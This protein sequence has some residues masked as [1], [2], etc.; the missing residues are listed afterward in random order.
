METGV[1]AL[2]HHHAAGVPAWLMDVSWAAVQQQEDAT[3]WLSDAKQSFALVQRDSI[4][5]VVHA[6]LPLW[7]DTVLDL[8]T[9]SPL[10]FSH[11]KIRRE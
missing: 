8:P 3:L 5:F 11:Q 7:T 6:T 2:A 10:R 4:L 1:L 9:L